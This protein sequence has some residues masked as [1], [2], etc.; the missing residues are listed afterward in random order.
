MLDGVVLDGWARER[1]GKAPDRGRQSG[2][3]QAPGCGA[4]E[5]RLTKTAIFVMALCAAQ[6]SSQ[7]AA[8]EV[9][10]GPA[11]V[12]LGPRT[13]TV[14]WLVSDARTTLGESADQLS[15]VAKTVQVRKSVYTGLK[16][17]T[18]YFYA[19]PAG[20]GHFK[21]PPAANAATPFTFL[22]YGDVRTRDE[23]HAQVIARAQQADPDFVI[24]TGDLV[25]DGTDTALWPNFFRIEA[26]LL[27]KTAF[28]PSLGNHEKN[29]PQYYEFLNAKSGYYSFNWGNA[30]FSI[31]NTDIRN[32][33]AGTEEQERYWKEQV[34]WLEQDLIR[35]QN[36]DFRFV[37]GHHP[38]FTAVSSR[39][40]DNAHIIALVPM[41]EK[42][43]VTAMLN[44]HD[45]NYQR[46][47]KK[48]VQYIVTGGGGAPLYNVDM[49][50]AYITKRVEKIENFV[51]IRIDGKRATG[52]TIAIDGH[53]IDRFEFKAAQ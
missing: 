44:G 4:R 30:H 11:V 6:L 2:G 27:S 42:Y 35:S 19:T 39:Q 12:N 46:Y 21:T 5:V 38:P 8:E 49:P 18:T 40:G 53:L 25:A 36:A 34:A 23:V 16:L 47:E 48:D 37:A 32:A 51:R 3:H 10:A 52:E 43:K 14:I 13:A 15:R 26:P 17:G 41:M 1:M 45:H 50:P 20:K 7:G 28:Y 24:H 33:A 9:L 31:I 22:V 29:D